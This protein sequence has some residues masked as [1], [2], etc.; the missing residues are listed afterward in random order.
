M[1]SAAGGDVRLT[2]SVAV[3]SVNNWAGS[4][5][6]A[7]AAELEVFMML[8]WGREADGWRRAGDDGSCGGV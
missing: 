7:V 4:K 1:R 2:S 8:G 6:I 5:T 3:L